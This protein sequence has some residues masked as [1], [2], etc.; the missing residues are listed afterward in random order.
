[1]FFRLDVCFYPRSRLQLVGLL[2][3]FAAA[4]STEVIGKVVALWFPTMAFVALGMEHCIANM[5]F[6]PLGIFTGT[7]ARYLALVNAGEAKS[8]GCRLE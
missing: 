6:I 5:F 8:T 2:S 4:A 1:M 3:G 7:D